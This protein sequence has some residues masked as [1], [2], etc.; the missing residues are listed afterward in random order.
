MSDR[1]SKT[2]FVNSSSVYI[3]EFK[4][5]KLISRRTDNIMTKRKRTN[6]ALQ[7]NTQTNN[8]RATRTPLKTRGEHMCCGVSSIGS[9]SGTRRVTLVTHPMASR[10]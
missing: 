8:D 1:L 7:N 2:N 5:T 6:I 4:D 10:G 3:E 9:T